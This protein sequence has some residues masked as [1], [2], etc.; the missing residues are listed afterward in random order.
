M[1]D[2]TFLLDVPYTEIST[3][4]NFEFLLNGLLPYRAYD[5]YVVGIDS[6]TANS[7]NIITMRT[8]TDRPGSPPLDISTY[9]TNPFTIR[10]TWSPPDRETQNGVITRYTIKYRRT[11]RRVESFISISAT[12]NSFDMSNLD[13]YTSYTLSIAAATSAGVGVYN[14]ELETRTQ[15]GVPT[16][17]PEMRF[18]SKTPTTISVLLQP[19]DIEDVNG[20]LAHYLVT[21]KGN[22]VDTEERSIAF[23]ALNISNKQTIPINAALIGLMEG[24]EYNIK[25]RIHTTQG[26]GPYSFFIAVTTTE[27][28]PSGPPLHVHFEGLYPTKLDFSWNPPNLELQNQKSHHWL[29]HPVSWFTCR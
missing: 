21:Y 10:L 1:R 16:A 20:I 2:V 8:L 27:I 17:S 25:A 7:S 22:V 29:Y 28:A 6:Q 13:E 12:L 18:L 24:V 23:S 3:T 26:G 11:D 9:S 4:R 19:P 5:I 15:E 14:S